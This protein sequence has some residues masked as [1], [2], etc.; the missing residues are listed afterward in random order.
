MENK[1]RSDFF[2]NL[3]GILIILVL[4]GHFGGDNTSFTPDGNLVLQTVELFIYLFH[5]PLMFFISGLFSKNIEKCRKNAFWDLFIP[6]LLFQIFYAIIQLF[7]SGNKAYLLNPFYPAPALWYLLALFVFRFFLMDFIRIKYN[8]VIAVLISILGICILGL[9]HLFAMN[10][11][12]ANFIYFLLGYYIEPQKI[13]KIR[14]SALNHQLIRVLLYVLA[15][16]VSSGIFATLFFILRSETISFTNLL[17]LIGRSKNIADVGIGLLYGPII[18]TV[19]I[20]LACILSFILIMITPERKC[21]LSVVG[22]DTLPLYLSHMLIQLLYLVAQRRYFFFE[23]WTVNWF[24]S[25]IPVILCV[26][27][28]SSKWY[29]NGFH[30]ILNAVKKLI[31]K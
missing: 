5:M 24:L 6:Y 25:L 26:W 3:R 2:D 10:R 17:G 13:L 27:L 12:F 21:Y 9:S 4:I 16:L 8:L 20:V 19:G 14:K 31:S 7:Y 28:F 30:K 22:Q 1:I 15:F 11:I 18:S 23:S 29:R